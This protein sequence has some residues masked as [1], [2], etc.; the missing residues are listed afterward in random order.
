MARMPAAPPPPPA[1]PPVHRARL[2]EIDPRTAYRLWKLRTDV[3]VVEQECP[4]PEL[5]GRDLEAT[6]EHLWIEEDGLPVAYLRLLVEVG[7]EGRDPAGTVR[8]GRVVTEP[9]HRGRGLGAHL[10]RAADGVI[11]DRA[12][13]LDA[14]SHLRFWYARFGYRVNGAE[15]VEDGIPHVPMR[16]DAVGDLAR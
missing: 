13:V 4:Y 10:L 5:D 11:A 3:F 7:D 14:Q 9:S 6:T 8:V 12:V 16:R 1:P 2:D 15:F